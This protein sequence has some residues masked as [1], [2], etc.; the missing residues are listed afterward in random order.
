MNTSL[1]AA[2]FMRTIMRPLITHRSH[3]ASSAAADVMC[4]TRC[5]RKATLPIW[6]TGV[7]IYDC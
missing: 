3:I 2:G 4:V 1:R 7:T 6:L 5:K